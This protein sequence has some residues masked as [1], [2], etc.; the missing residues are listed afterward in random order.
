MNVTSLKAL[1]ITGATILTLSAKA[2]EATD[3]MTLLEIKKLTEE[4]K[5]SNL[6]SKEI[7]NKLN[8]VLT[9]LNIMAIKMNEIIKNNN[10]EEEEKETNTNKK[11][12]IK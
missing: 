4:M 6:S 12:A 10:K 8:D 1:I 2:N 7:N 5:Q 9:S 3:H 11:V